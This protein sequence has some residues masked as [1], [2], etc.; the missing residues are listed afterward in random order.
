M[1]L[2]NKL[3]LSRILMV[4][5]FVFFTSVEHNIYCQLTALCL[6]ILA[7]ITD[8]LDGR[9]ARSRNMVT[10][11]GKFMDPIADKLLVMS[12]LVMMVEQGR[13]PG[14]VCM[15]MLAREFIVSGFRLVAATQGSVIAAGVWG[16]F[17]TLSQ[18]IYI[19]M[20]LILTP[21][22]SVDMADIHNI[23]EIL[24]ELMMYLSLALTLW[25]GFDYIWKNREYIKEM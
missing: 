2:P 22:Q 7:S 13:M 6:F 17:K 19:P 16:K 14:W 3:T 24:T 5:L 9:I 25:S 4:P 12:A 23:W 10:N 1:N 8:L 20:A 18:M 21:I 11:F 15:L